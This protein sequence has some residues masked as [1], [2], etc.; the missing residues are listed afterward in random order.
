M[1][2]HAPIFFE[3]QLKQNAILQALRKMDGSFCSLIHK[4]NFGVYGLARQA[5]H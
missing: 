2:I 3:E 5:E 4:D 1:L